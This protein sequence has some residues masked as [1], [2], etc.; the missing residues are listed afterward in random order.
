MHEQ[1]KR[2]QESEDQEKSDN[3]DRSSTTADSNAPEHLTWNQIVTGWKEYRSKAAAVDS[4][5][6]VRRVG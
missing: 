4:Y 3:V 5:S 1:D 2:Q 6:Q